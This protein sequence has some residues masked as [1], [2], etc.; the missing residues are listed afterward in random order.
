M[1]DLADDLHRG[2]LAAFAAL[3]DAIGGDV[4]TRGGV[5]AVLTGLPVAFFNPVW[6]P[7]ASSD[8]EDDLD[9]L[10]VTGQ[11]RGIPIRVS[12]PEGSDHEC[13]VGT[14]ATARGLE[15]QDA[16][17][18]GMAL[19]D[20]TTLPATPADV[21]VEQVTSAA[22]MGDVTALTMAA[23]EMPAALAEQVTG[24]HLASNPD[25]HWIVLRQDGDAVATAMV[26]VTGDVA[27]IFNVGVPPAHRRHGHGATATWEAIRLGVE[28]GARVAVLEA[29]PMGLPVYERMGFQTVVRARSFLSPTT[30]D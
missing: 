9:A 21:A 26:V 29:S 19:D 4:L 25:L 1:R 6:V 14:V 7:H 22:A 27:G 28:H 20:L 17:S 12:V 5:T 8:L 30:S 3:A 23:F 16:R 24:P 18:P 2:L 10:V 13:R 15:P 11:D